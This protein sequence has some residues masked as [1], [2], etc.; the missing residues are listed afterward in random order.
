MIQTC[1]NPSYL[2]DKDMYVPCG[3]C[4]AC[5]SA[6]T[7][8]WLDRLDNEA[9]M[10]ASVLFIT[11]T[12]DNEHVP[13]L[14]YDEGAKAFYSNRTPNDDIY[15]DDYHQYDLFFRFPQVEDR[16]NVFTNN[17]KKC[18]YVNKTDVQKFLK[19]LRSLIAYDRENLIPENANKALRYFI[20]SEYGP[21]TYRAHYHGLLFFSDLSVSQ[22]VERCYFSQAWKLCSESNKRCEFVTTS[23]SGYCAKYINCVTHTPDI[24]KIHGKTATFF[25]SSR[26]PSIG[27]QYFNYNDLVNKIQHR[28]LEYSKVYTTREGQKESS[29]YIPKSNLLYFFEKPY[30]PSSFDRIDYIRF[31]DSAAKYLT[32]SDIEKVKSMPCLVSSYDYISAVLP[33]YIHEVEGK[34][35][36][37]TNYYDDPSIPPTYETLDLKDIYPRLTNLEKIYGIPQNRRLLIRSLVIMMREE[38]TLHDY[39]ERYF[40]FFN[41]RFDC[42]MSQMYECY[43]DY[44]NEG[45]TPLNAMR[46]VYPSFFRAL[47]KSFDELLKSSDCAFVLNTFDNFKI[48]WDD[49]FELFT[50]TGGKKPD[51]F[52]KAIFRD[53]RTDNEYIQYIDYLTDN[54]TK[55]QKNRVDTHITNQ[56]NIET[57]ESF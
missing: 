40:S 47:P 25:L 2:K 20:V 38:I 5:R 15:V 4:L 54:E 11:L 10:S 18:S 49:V 39:L 1:D 7:A 45:M 50:I 23:A 24:L 22:A 41:L 44:V 30:S 52:D 31:F 8:H 43:N 42:S 12:Y 37:V 21:K 35:T 17:L 16:R 19:R 3:Q 14:E 56:E 26:R 33:S 51:M 28:T 55:F 13:L 57:Y 29:K 32:S 27:S 6:K 36:I 53:L 34:R 46:R 48:A 9:R